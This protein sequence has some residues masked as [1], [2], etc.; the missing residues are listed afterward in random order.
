MIRFSVPTTVFLLFIVP[1]VLLGLLRFL[2]W[3]RHRKGVRP[4]F[5]DRLLRSPGETL[6]RQIEDINDDVATYMIGANT[7]PLFLAR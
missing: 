5:S 6:R 7:F 1:F 4:P 3:A 2:K